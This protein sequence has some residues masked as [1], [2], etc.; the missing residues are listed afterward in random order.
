[1]GGE[2]REVKMQDLENDGPNGRAAECIDA[3]KYF[4]LSFS[5]TDETRRGSTFLT[6]PVNTLIFHFLALILCP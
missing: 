3:C 1:M 5:S 4:D 6:H 2:G